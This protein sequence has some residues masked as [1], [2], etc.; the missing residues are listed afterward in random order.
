MYWWGANQ[1]DLDGYHLTTG[2]TFQDSC[3]KWLGVVGRY[4]ILS[5]HFSVK[6]Y[7]TIMIIYYC[8]F[9]MGNL[10]REI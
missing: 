6:S 2:D 5:W 10:K 4:I 9:W 3:P 8:L 1:V 7:L